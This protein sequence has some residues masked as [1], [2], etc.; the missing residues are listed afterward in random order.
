MLD[1]PTPTPKTAWIEDFRQPKIIAKYLFLLVV[2]VGVLFILSENY[3][4]G[5]DWRYTFSPLWRNWADPF[6]IPG[7][8]NPPWVIFLMPHSILPLK[9][10]NAV[11]LLLNITI[12]AI[13]IGKYAA[14]DGPKTFIP[15]LLMLFTFPPFLDLVRTNNI[16]WVPILAFLLP[17][18]WAIATLAIKPQTMG[19]AALI[20][21]KKSKFSLRVLLPL[22]FFIVF[23]FVVW[24]IWFER[25]DW[26]IVRKPWEAANFSP[27]P[28]MIPLGLYMFY[29]A[30]RT[31]DDV[32]AAVATPFLTPYYAGYSLVPILT[33]LMTKYRREAFMVYV[34]FWLY[35]IIEG[36]RRGLF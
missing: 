10:S 11:N 13:L 28:F 22:I 20:W 14:K 1:Q 12:P 16:E 5:V 2:V 3:P 26:E 25:I 35:F 33:V 21:W 15:M 23:S 36:K 8:A 24:G 6:E 4:I 31:D 27:F 34:G 18:Q 9:L 7:L 17:P 29:K 30:Y 32:L 19:G